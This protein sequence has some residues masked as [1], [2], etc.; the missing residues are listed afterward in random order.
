MRSAT[1]ALVAVLL[2]AASS[3]QAQELKNLKVFPPDTEKRVLIDAMKQWTDALG[4]R[5]T[6][7]HVQ[8]VP[9]DFQSFDFASDD[10]EH[11]ETARRMLR[12]VQDLNKDVL[13]Q[14]AG[15]DDAHVS[16]VTCHRGLTNPA[17]LDQVI[18]RKATSEGSTAAVETY[19]QL[20]E[21]YYGSGS[22]DFG[23]HALV[24]AIEKLATTGDDPAGARALIDLNIA[25][26]PE[27]AD[28]RVMLAQLL[29]MQGD[30]EGAS[31]AVAKALELDPQN[32]QAARL[33]KQL[34]Q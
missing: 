8:K 15:E 14:A 32:H 1:H 22:Y 19:H 24:P 5:C 12:M 13:P 30:K 7:C 9:G 16:C 29:M 21:R 17:T 31:A 26:Y 3:A 2:L 10:L 18:L 25:E 28:S 20:R 6:Y 11:K 23:P 34:Q 33:Q 4:V 27:D